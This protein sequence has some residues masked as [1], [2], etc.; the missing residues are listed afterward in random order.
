MQGAL[1][2]GNFQ[3]VRMNVSPLNVISLAA[4]HPVSP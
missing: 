3:L 1:G 2:S 4:A